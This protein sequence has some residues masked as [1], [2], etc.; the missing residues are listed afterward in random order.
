MLGAFNAARYVGVLHPGPVSLEQYAKYYTRY[1]AAKAVADMPQA[2]LTQAQVEAVN[3]SLGLL[4]EAARNVF[5]EATARL[6]PEDALFL[7]GLITRQ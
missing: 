5:A 2:G 3:Q 1:Q 4:L 6:A 7:Q